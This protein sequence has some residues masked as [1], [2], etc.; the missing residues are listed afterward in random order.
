MLAERIQGQ[1]I[2]SARLPGQHSFHRP[3]LA[4]ISDGRPIAVELELSP[5]GPSRLEPIIGAWKKAHWVSEVR[6]YAEPGTTRRGVERAI[7][8]ANASSRIHIYEAPAR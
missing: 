6:Y 5:K 1:P 2:V 8:K 7:Q 4:V 3:D